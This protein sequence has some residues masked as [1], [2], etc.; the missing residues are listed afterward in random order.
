MK[1]W[2]ITILSCCC[3][4]WIATPIQA[5]EILFSEDF[6]Q[7]LEKWQPT[8][9]DGS[10]WTV[11]DERAIVT[12]PFGSTISE[13]VPKDPYWDPSWKNISYQLDFTPLVGTDKNISFGFQDTCNWY[14]THFTDTFVNLVRLKDCIVPFG[15]SHEFSMHNG[16]TYHLEIRFLNGLISLYIDQVLVSEDQD[17]SFNQN[18]GKIGLK[19]GT[20]ASYPTVLAYDNI[21]VTSLD[22]IELGVSGLKQTEPE[23]QDE[24]YDSAEKWSDQPTIHR[25]GC[26]LVSLTMILQYHG[27][28][29]L[30]DGTSVTPA[31]LN[32]WLRQQPDGYLGQGIVNWAA[33][34]RLTRLI[35]E[36]FQTPKL[37]YKVVKD[38]TLTTAIA[39][40][41][42]HKP[43]IL[44]L[45]GHFLVA[46]G[47]TRDQEDVFIKD[48]AYGYDRFSQHQAELLS[49]RTFQPSHTDLSY[50]VIAHSA[51]MNVTLTDEQGHTPSA[52][53]SL[54]E[55][56]TDP[57]DGSQQRTTLE[58]KIMA[59]P[60][61]GTY[62]LTIS[63]SQLG[64]FNFQFFVYDAAGTVTT[65]SQE[66]WL[67][68]QAQTYRLTYDRSGSR[69]ILRP[70]LTWDQFHQDLRQVKRQGGF[71]TWSAYWLL[72]QTISWAKVNKRHSPVEYTRLLALQLYVYRPWILTN[73]YRY[74][75]QQLN[76]LHHSF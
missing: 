5:E 41:T 23:W 13:M 51:N 2:L 40:I 15:V 62:L 3:F 36:Q 68:P 60:S 24:I 20:G 17:W 54:T 63:Q 26:A 73:Q 14:E 72:D 12:I 71:G 50:F 33:A 66:G 30:P 37:E 22:Q 6:S 45:D 74:L 35:S 44:Q 52:L 9:D 48:P 49:T 1:H 32:A 47:V 19:A 28:S 38:T 64:P 21:Q 16:Q 4:F 27:I 70:T 11:V 53:Q 39:E 31:T 46:D 29:F 18:Y 10:Y 55:T 69:P 75:Y 65:L 67:G 61:A 58:E 7:G 8:R 57:V 25:W 43:V 34:M 76:K 42:N 59:Q 56:L